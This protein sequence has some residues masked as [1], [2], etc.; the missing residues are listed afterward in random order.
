MNTPKISCHSVKSSAFNRSQRAHSLR[1]T[2][3]AIACAVALGGGTGAA[4]AATDLSG[5]PLFALVGISPNITL[6]IDDS[7]SMAWAAVP[8]AKVTNDSGK[9]WIS[10][11]YNAMYYNPNNRY[12]AP[13]DQNGAPL[14]TSWPVAYLNGFN[15]SRGTIDLTNKYQATQQY[16][17]TSTSQTRN[18][19]P[20]GYPHYA[21]LNLANVGCNSTL[22]DTTGAYT[23][24]NCYTAVTVSSTSGPATADINNDGV[25]DAADKDERQ[26]F[27]NWYSFYRTRNLAIM[28]GA[29]IAFSQLDP[30]V[31]VAFQSLNLCTAFNTACKDSA[32][33]SYDNRITTFTGTAR[34]NF[35]KWLQHTPA[36]NG[37]P[38]LQ[39]VERAGAMYTTS[40][41]YDKDPG[42]TPNP[43]YECRGNFSII[44]TDGIWNG[45]L[46]SAA[47]GNF[48]NVAHGLPDGVTY[49]A[50][51]PYASAQTNNMADITMRYWA[52]DLSALPQSPAL[53]Y[54]P[55]KSNETIGTKD[56]T[57]YWNPKNDPATWQHMVTFT[58]GLGLKSWLGS[59][60]G[61]ETHAT[62][63]GAY[64][65]L[66]DGSK[67][68]PATGN[69]SIPG[70]VYDLWHAALN[71]RGGFYSA[72]SPD[73]VV[74][75]F[76]DIIKGIIDRKGSATAAS[77]SN[78][79]LNA[80]IFI[81]QTEFNTANWT[82]NMY[83]YGLSN[84]SNDG[85]GCN[86]LARGVICPNKTWEA[87][88]QLDALSWDTGR[89]LITNV[90]GAGKPFRWLNLSAVQ[91]ADLTQ[92]D[93]L[94]G[95]RLEY[96]RGSRTEE[97][98]GTNGKPFR[99]RDHI[100]GDII[101]SAPAPL[102]VGAPSFY[103]PDDLSYA[104]FYTAQAGRKQVV[105]V[106]AND[107]MLHAF[108]ALTGAELL[109]FVPNAVFPNLY[110]LTKTDYSHQSYVDGSMIGYDVKI[111]G[112]WK[113][114][115]YAGLGLGGK[116]V[117]A[118]DI[119]DPTN[120]SEGNANSIFKWEFTDPNLGYT[121]GKP[122]VIQ[123][124]VGGL[125]RT[126]VVFG[127]GFT[128]GATKAALYIVDAATGALIS[129]VA[130]N[131]HAGATN[132]TDN[133]LIGITPVDTQGL[134]ASDPADGIAD[135]VYAGDLYGN[136]W[137]F[138]LTGAAPAVAFGTAAEPEPWFVAK[139]STNARQPITTEPSVTRHP[140]RNGVIVYFGTGKYLGL[141]DSTDNQVQ[142]MYAVWDK[143]NEPTN[144]MTRSHLL[145]QNILVDYTTYFTAT[146]ARVT[147][148]CAI[149]WHDTDD[150]SLPGAVGSCP[151]ATNVNNNEAMG[152]YI[153]LNTEAG[154]RVHQ[155]PIVR[156]DRVIFV[157]V[158]PSL[159]PCAAGGA[160]WIYEFQANSGSRLLTTTPFDYNGD[161]KL[162][163]SDFVQK[164]GG[165]AGDM[166]PASGIRFDGAGV[167]YL[168]KESVIQDGDKEIKML[169]SS[170]GKVIGLGE[171]SSTA[172]R[173][174]WHEVIAE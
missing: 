20:T 51:S 71:G 5:I 90:A 59:D 24:N 25:V 117:Y 142:T 61:G 18:T 122:K 168:D 172:L 53:T 103:H 14:S 162:D 113:T 150:N 80:G 106:G 62:A 4:Y 157:T 101:N 125:V 16:D 174:T 15:T 170:T 13:P 147:S 124:R 148:S 76:N 165:L 158:T 68:W 108:D 21:V 85:T 69:D 34:Q 28:S 114:Y 107:G 40:R 10:S 47:T 70:N 144:L 39:A 45:G 26:N 52:T 86:N 6:T 173:R 160:S 89:Q 130:V 38:L 138:D 66:A 50:T 78:P 29:S 91:Q 49:N 164:P 54:M 17:P 31:R 60:W 149:K 118:L 99:K 131:N 127:S 43:Q 67:S 72:E 145:Q 109:G 73:D 37:T 82:G 139:D 137:K 121:Y 3:L 123:V 119:T 36:N 94:G 171:S 98:D 58:I 96:L 132:F 105:Y 159:D 115:L 128:D 146:D 136:L 56:F 126:A 154:E 111:G 64:P 48:D 155:A 32:N 112:N 104:A 166:I 95:K 12:P 161:T 35:F 153:D 163:K 151:A 7:G 27:A 97:N 120:F 100:M 44:M 57:P 102:F 156:G 169:S 129:R 19:A 63:T 1:L 93:T 84:G 22:K 133:G 41:P 143:Q 110:K 83:A 75:A 65:Q 88:P 8:D 30:D 92:S 141:S 135:A 23:D 152:W 74:R 81:Y 140:T 77:L 11:S 9:R 79:N 134:T 55:V 42:V 2:T 33:T 46:A 116:S 167:V 87:Q